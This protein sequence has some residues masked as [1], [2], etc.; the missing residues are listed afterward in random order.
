MKLFS[1]FTKCFQTYIS[2]ETSFHKAKV[3]M[4][5]LSLGDT[6]IAYILV[7]ALLCCLLPLLYRPIKLNYTIPLPSTEKEME[8][9][10]R[11][12]VSLYH[13]PKLDLPYHFL[14]HL[15]KG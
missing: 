1:A 15:N 2:L 7:L 8:A 9:N 6:S 12:G 11:G 14:K 3:Q 5:F 13:K 10:I 4:H